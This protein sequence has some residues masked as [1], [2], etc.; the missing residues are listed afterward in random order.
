MTAS[1]SISQA[2]V[3]TA[4]RSFILG[5][6]SC[7]V[8]QGLGNGVPPPVAPF[9]AMTPLYFERLST[10]TTEYVDPTPTTGSQGIC[11]H[12]MWVVQIDCYGPSSQDWAVVLTTLFRDPYAVTALGANVT[13]LHAD[14]PK[15]IPIV[16]GEENFEQRWLITAYL[17]YNPVVT[18]PMQFFDGVVVGLIDVET[19]Q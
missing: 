9:I 2:D 16:D 14:D 4:L 10:N 3:F 6:I 7:E 15:Q 19:I 8:V 5:L 13:P 17:Q 12:I 11:Q 1:V 18:I